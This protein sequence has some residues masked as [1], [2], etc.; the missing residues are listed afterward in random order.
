MLKK[1]FLSLSICRDYVKK[2]VRFRS[3]SSSLSWY[4]KQLLKVIFKNII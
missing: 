4:S 1:I 3:L 2:R